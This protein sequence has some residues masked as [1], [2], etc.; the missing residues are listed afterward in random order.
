MSKKY[1]LLLRIYSKWIFREYPTGHRKSALK[2]YCDFLHK[3]SGKLVN[4]T[5]EVKRAEKTFSRMFIDWTYRTH[6]KETI[7]TF[8]LKFPK[9]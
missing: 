1:P 3:V 6:M 9:H 8:R 2:Q 5:L 7:K 4:E